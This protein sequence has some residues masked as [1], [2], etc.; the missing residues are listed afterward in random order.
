MFD[1]IGDGF[2]NPRVNDYIINLIETMLPKARSDPKNCLLLE[3]WA[4]DPSPR[5]GWLKYYEEPLE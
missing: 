3:L 4:L 1:W 5:K 2:P